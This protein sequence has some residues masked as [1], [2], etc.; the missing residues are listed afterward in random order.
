VSALWNWKT[1]TFSGLYRGPGFALASLHYGLGEAARAGV[2][3]FVLFATIAGFTGALTQRVRHMR[4]VWA[5]G[6]VI[7][8]GIPSCLHAMEWVVHTTAGSPARGRGVAVSVAMTAVAE[9]FNWYSMRQGA[10]LAGP[11]GSPFL[12]DL[13]RIPSL[14]AGFV[15]WATRGGREPGRIAQTGRVTLK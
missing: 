5:A 12:D 7:L 2:T 11:E 8:L 1:A 4:P 15:V 10:M 6:L 3:E 13:K 14:V 9:L